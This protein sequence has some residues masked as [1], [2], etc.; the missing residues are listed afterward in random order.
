MLIKLL[1]RIPACHRAMLKIAFENQRKPKNFEGM[2]QVFIDSNGQ[3]YYKHDNDMDIPMARLA[4]LQ[5]LMM[6][7]GR[8]LTHDE[9]TSFLNYMD[10]ALQETVR[11][12][13]AD[14]DR[15]P[16]NGLSRIGHAI[17]EMRF[18]KDKLIHEDILY[19]LAAV[20]Y[21]REDEDPAVIDN[22]IAKAKIEQFKKDAAGGLHAF[23][24]QS[25]L[26]R[27]LP[28]SDM[29]EEELNAYLAESSIRIQAMAELM[30]KYLSGQPL[31]ASEK[32]MKE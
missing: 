29:S 14:K 4:E 24:M 19:A 13:K 16:V 15:K 26:R 25:G 2:S 30:G 3:R 23:F 12:P 32:Q 27:Y 5:V 6:E 1:S 17:T 21:I 8:C 11:P 10:Q 22:E 31:S 20:L 18:R 28:F 9:L 7:L